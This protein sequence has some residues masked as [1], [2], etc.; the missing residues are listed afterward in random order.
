MTMGGKKGGNTREQEILLH[1]GEVICTCRWFHTVFLDLK[2]SVFMLT[3]LL[4]GHKKDTSK[5]A[6][7]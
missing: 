1:L 4:S 5:T 3:P 2:N 7:N 6:V